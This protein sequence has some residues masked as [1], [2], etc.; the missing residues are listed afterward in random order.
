[1][2]KI[3]DTAIENL[4]KKLCREPDTIEISKELNIE[5]SKYLEWE[6][7]FQASTIKNIDVQNDLHHLSPAAPRAINKRCSIQAHDPNLGAKSKSEANRI[8]SASKLQ[9]ENADPAE[10]RSSIAVYYK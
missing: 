8:S 3:T 4:N 5:H 1:M 9:R 2:K 6:A 7:A 10:H